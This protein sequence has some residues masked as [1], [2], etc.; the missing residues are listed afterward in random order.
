MGVFLP[1]WA[2]TGQ[3]LADLIAEAAS[4]P[5]PD[6]TRCL[7]LLPDAAMRDTARRAWLRRHPAGWSPRLETLHS[8]AQSLP[9]AVAGSSASHG[10][11]G[12]ARVDALEARRRLRLAGW[13]AQDARELSG[14]LLAMTASLMQA[15]ALH[16]P[17]E[18]ARW[19]AGSRA[20][21]AQSAGH[22]GGTED[23]GATE[24]RLTGLAVQWVGESPGP[25]D[26][27]WQALAGDAQALLALLGGPTS[28]VVVQADA[29][30]GG[31]ERPFCDHPCVAA[32]AE[33]CGL[34]VRVIDGAPK[35]PPGPDGQRRRV[36][37]AEDGDAQVTQALH[38]IQAHLAAGHAPLA[39]ITSDRALARRMFVA[40]HLHGV[41]TLDRSGWRLSTTRRAAAI[42]AALRAAAPNAT[43]DDVLA[44]LKDCPAAAPDAVDGLERALRRAGVRRWAT[45]LA[46]LQRQSAPAMQPAGP[47]AAGA[48]RLVEQAQG[49]LRRWPR[50][51]ALGAWLQVLAMHLQDCGQWNALQRDAAGQAVLERLWLDG[52]GQLSAE[53]AA[54]LERRAIG[55]VPLGWTAFVRWL[56]DALE[57][58]SLP[59]RSPESGAV[60]PVELRTWG[61]FAHAWA[62][63]EWAAAVAVGCDA[64]SLP[65]MT[66]D[67]TGWQSG[68]RAQLGLPS[69]DDLSRRRQ[70]EW[71]GALGIAH[72]DVL[73]CRH[74]AAGQPQSP[75]PLLQR[76]QWSTPTPWPEQP[77][78]W[79]L[80]EIRPDTVAVPAPVGD[81][82]VLR[83]LSPSA[84][85]RLRAC[86]YQF[87]V[88][89]LLKLVRIEEL[90]VPADK[91][92]FGTWLHDVL[93]RYHQRLHASATVSRAEREQFLIEAAQRATAALA[94]EPGEFLPFELQWPR[95]ANAYLDW[96]IKWESQGARL[97]VAEADV[98]SSLRLRSNA[99]EGVQPAVLKLGGRIDRV[100]RVPAG[101]G[102]ETPFLLD[103]K[104][105][106]RDRSRD[107]I[108]PDSEDVQ[109]AFYA[110][111][112]RGSTPGHADPVQGAYLSFSDTVADE[113][114]RLVQ[115]P[116]LDRRRDQ[117]AQLIE[118]DLSR[119]F[120]GE[121]LRPLGDIQTCERC[122][123][124][125]ICR[126][127]DWG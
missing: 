53:G 68:E 36:W 16:A 40:L 15:A 83:K 35:A 17:P 99:G 51:A 46:H 122:E 32:L 118:E 124:R 110:L 55:R 88:L 70:A 30:R 74:D 26:P 102:Q 64:L 37:V 111:A 127:D 108:K 93:H 87:H 120:Q 116:D 31:G 71:D 66:I 18:R 65:P 24:R 121:A 1:G 54:E 125:G 29:E 59:S 85:E 25:L 77:V 4:S 61:Q 58:A 101:D 113:P 27:L 56:G 3:G 104:T 78:Q 44:W 19:L 45:W 98:S 79:P 100:D 82:R 90:D 2:V 48:L 67:R 20:T 105:E 73:W 72:V 7:V 6:L 22:P 39:L 47:A 92:D 112:W 11:A 10:F 23:I 62:A 28:L 52:D 89:H 95:M 114:C 81:L 13:S 75:S 109:L 42:M 103:Y 91:R 107:R 94:L 84:Y 14:R 12:D 8:L 86:P 5:G 50:Q 41:D 69:R 34:A 63:D 49:W 123:A 21:W 106:R 115:M 9:G 33:R 97:L 117:L 119:L 38:C 80:R 43:C 76:W 96:Q 126:R 57:S 60:A